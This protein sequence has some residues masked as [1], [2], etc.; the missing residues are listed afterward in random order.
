MNSIILHDSA[1]GGWL[2]RI[3]FGTSAA[4]EDSINHSA[5]ERNLDATDIVNRSILLAKFV[6]DE[7]FERLVVT[8]K[9][10]TTSYFDGD[11]YPDILPD[12]GDMVAGDV[13]VNMSD[14]ARQ[15][16]EEI[17]QNHP[18]HNLSAVMNHL[19]AVYFR[20]NEYAHQGHT[21]SGVRG[22][23]SSEIFF[24]PGDLV[25]PT[26]EVTVTPSDLPE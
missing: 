1:E 5:N 9:D 14:V 15:A 3:R 16:L 7:K 8:D 25:E 6:K 19:A 4:N 21:I 26:H 2:W 10:R 20:L 12:A 23:G 13:E 22:D 11:M 17:L 24:M 18:E